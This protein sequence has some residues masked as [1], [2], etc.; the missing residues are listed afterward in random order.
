MARHRGRTHSTKCVSSQK[1][2]LSQNKT[3]RTC[4]SSH[5]LRE[6]FLNRTRWIH[7]ADPVYSNRHTNRHLLRCYASA[8]TP[9]QNS[10]FAITLPLVT[11]D[12]PRTYEQSKISAAASRHSVC[13]CGLV[14]MKYIQVQA[15]NDQCLSRGATGALLRRLSSSLSLCDGLKLLYSNIS[16]PKHRI[17][18]RHRSGGFRN[19]GHELLHKFVHPGGSGREAIAVTAD[20]IEGR[21]GQ[22]QTAKLT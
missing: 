11:Y 15:R 18:F 16:L 13:F 19:L 9:S 20:Q 5:F 7:R 6:N 17:L 2:D 22:S 21:A 1:L 10:K 14:C 8:I 4:T 12:V 3:C